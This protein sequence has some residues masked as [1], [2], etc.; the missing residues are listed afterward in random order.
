MCLP[1]HRPGP[2]SSCR[3]GAFSRSQSAN[4]RIVMEAFG[5]CKNQISEMSSTHSCDVPVLGAFAF[6]SRVPDRKRCVSLTR[7]RTAGFGYKSTTVQCFQQSLHEEA[8]HNKPQPLQES[9][10]SMLDL[11][12]PRQIVCALGACRLANK[13]KSCDKYVLNQTFLEDEIKAGF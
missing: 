3:S 2:W 11:L 13:S 12:P 5:S 10:G 9:I 6:E 8:P 1:N 7:T 4:L